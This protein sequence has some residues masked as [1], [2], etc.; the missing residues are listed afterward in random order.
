M[1]ESLSDRLQTVFQKLGSKGKLTEDDVR[2]AMKQV[3]LALLEADVNFKVVK[4]FVAKVTEQAIGEDVTKSLTPHQ[5]VVKIVHQELINLLGTDNVPLQESRPGPT[6]IMLVGLQGTG[7]TTLSAKLALHLRKK[8]RRVLLAAC[9][10]YRPAAI[11]QLESLGKQLG[12]TVYSEPG[13]KHPPDIATHAVELAKKELYNVV[14]VDTAGRLQID[15]LLMQELEQIDACVQP[16]ERLLVVDAMTGQEAVRVAETFNQRVNITGL[17]M[18]KMDGDAR[19][20]AALSVRS[21]T[22]VPIKFISSGEKID[23]NT[24][25]A[26]HPDR[27]ASR[28]LGMGDVLSLIEK[29]E[30]MYDAEQA[31]RMEKR[32]RKGKFDFEDFLSAMQQMRKLG[33]LQQ[34]IGMIPGMSQLARDEELVSEK[35]LKLIEA[36]IFSMT[37]DERRNPELIKGSRRER[38]AKGSGTSVQE[39]SQLVKQFQQMQRMM[40]QMGK[41]MG[42][43]GRG[44]RGG[45]GGGSPLNPED[46]MRM[47]K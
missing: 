15:D 24:L 23:L 16:I 44:G 46:L 30:E 21:V 8:G 38:I 39:V 25:E 3:R 18:T 1:F 17:V 45:R 31:K 9:D 14:I 28:I 10:I 2:E 26:F 41:N 7:K 34:I 40:K 43:K 19:G 11:T 27:L 20:G 22:G 6:V 35:Q 42:G 47:L 4:E 37:I 5:Q 29:A 13:S 32:L 12:I 36:I 33:P